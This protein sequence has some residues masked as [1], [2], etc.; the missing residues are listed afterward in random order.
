MPHAFWAGQVPPEDA[1]P[2]PVD[3]RDL[4]PDAG[5]PTGAGEELT[6]SPD[7]RSLVLAQDVPEGTAG[8]RTRLVLVET[9]GGAGLTLLCTELRFG[10]S[11]AGG[12]STVEGIVGSSVASL[13][14]T[15]RE[16]P[17]ERG[18]VSL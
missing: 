10:G 1:T 6:L 14:G 17:L 8:R 16:P 15:A 2:A 3:L 5:P 12:T 18:T 9:A 4:T 11:S 7:G 13:R